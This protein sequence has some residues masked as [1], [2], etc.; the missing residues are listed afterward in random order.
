MHG[1]VMISVPSAPSAV[2]RYFPHHHW[3]GATPSWMRPMKHRLSSGDRQ[4]MVS[5]LPASAVD[6]DAEMARV[7]P[8]PPPVATGGV[9][10]PS[11][12]TS[13]AMTGGVSGSVACSDEPVP[14]ALRP[15][16]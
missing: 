8:P 5:G 6:G 11:G 4:R 10:G 12:F 14:V 7:C 3:V 1:V 2:E 15:R 16:S 9:L 13:V